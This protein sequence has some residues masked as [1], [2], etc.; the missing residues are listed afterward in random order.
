MP[1]NYY[2][3]ITDILIQFKGVANT[4]WKVNMAVANNQG[5]SSISSIQITGNENYFCVK[6]SLLELTNGTR[7][8]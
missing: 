7:I 2:F 1:I 4:Q 5:G 3:M 8:F 6:H